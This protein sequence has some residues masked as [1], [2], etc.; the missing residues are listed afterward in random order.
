[1]RTVILLTN[2]QKTKKNKANTTSLTAVITIEITIRAKID[3]F[4]VVTITFS[5][6]LVNE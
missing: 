3:Q 1:L 6:H 2:K 5:P 4:T